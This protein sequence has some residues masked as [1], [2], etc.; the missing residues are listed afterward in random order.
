MARGGA[1]REGDTESEVGSGLR[2]V[3]AE[4]DAGLELM[5]CE[6]VTKSDVQLTELPGAPPR[7]GSG[8]TPL[9]LPQGERLLGLLQGLQYSPCSWAESTHHFPPPRSLLSGRFPGPC[10]SRGPFLQTSWLTL[11]RA[12]RCPVWAHV[13]DLSQP[14]QLIRPDVLGRAP[15][16]IPP[17]ARDLGSCESESQL[18][19]G[20][21]GL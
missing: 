21:R 5:S 6:I 3:C 11:G 20:A 19:R 13:L 2:A 7:Q 18:S 4:P 14:E 1:E 8:V 17:S 9:W 12:I 10:P 16:L 15:H